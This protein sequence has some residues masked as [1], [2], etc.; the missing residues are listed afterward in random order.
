MVS[1]IMDMEVMSRVPVVWA[2]PDVVVASEPPRTSFLFVDIEVLSRCGE[3][4]ATRTYS[5][6][7][8][9]FLVQ[10]TSHPGKNY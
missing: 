4:S 5:S 1:Q 7:S 9:S 8:G 3:L 6:A 10:Q 2:T